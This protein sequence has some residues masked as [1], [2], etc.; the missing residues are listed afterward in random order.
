MADRPDSPASPARLLFLIAVVVAVL[1]FVYGG[2]A[3]A[4]APAT[5]QD[6]Q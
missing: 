2:M 6:R 1:V 3:H 4:R 5:T